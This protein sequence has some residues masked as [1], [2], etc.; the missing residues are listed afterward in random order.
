MLTHQLSEPLRRG[1]R[2]VPKLRSTYIPNNNNVGFTFAVNGIFRLSYLSLQPP[3]DILTQQKRHSHCIPLMAFTKKKKKRRKKE[4]I[5]DC[6]SLFVC[7]TF[8]LS[9]SQTLPTSL[10]TETQSLANSELVLSLIPF[11]ST[12]NCFKSFLFQFYLT[13]KQK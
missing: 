6:V 1:W 11:F 4:N 10:F 8:V 2:T 7:E 13:W 3:S 9:C 5:F 12:S